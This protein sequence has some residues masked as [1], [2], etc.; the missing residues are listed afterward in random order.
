MKRYAISLLVLF[1]LLVTVQAAVAQQP[2]T[3]G[4]IW[5][6]LF[7]RLK[8]GHTVNEYAESFSKFTLPAVQEEKRQGLI[9]DFKTLLNNKKADAQDWDILV[10]YEFKDQASF[11]SFVPKET[12]LEL[13]A[14]GGKEGHDKLAADRAAMKDTM[15]VAFVKEITL[16]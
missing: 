12:A 6:V 7:I 15:R 1:L 14:A 9:L 8:P 4:P 13:Q 5:R 16:K 11:D 2:Y 10:A 3:E